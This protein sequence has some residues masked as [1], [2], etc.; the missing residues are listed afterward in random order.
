MILTQGN[1]VCLRDMYAIILISSHAHDILV[2]SPIF[3]LLQMRQARDLYVRLAAKVMNGVG[4]G[5]VEVEVEVKGQAE[6]VGRKTCDN[7]G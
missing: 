6:D 1:Y 3:R 7:V 2:I 4:V 5:S